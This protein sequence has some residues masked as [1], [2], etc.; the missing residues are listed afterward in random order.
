V[1]LRF[2]ESDGELRRAL[3]VTKSRTSSHA[4]TIHELLLHS[5]G[6]EIGEP[7]KGFE[8]VLTGLPTYRGDTRMMVSPDH[9]GK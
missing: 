8:G 5:E 1:L 7:L 3:A 2:F 6:I 9:V 4:P